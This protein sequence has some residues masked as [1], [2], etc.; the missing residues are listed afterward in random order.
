[1]Y[2]NKIHQDEEN[3]GCLKK[4]GDITALRKSQL[5]LTH[6]ILHD[7]DSPLNDTNH[8]LC[9][10]EFCALIFYVKRHQQ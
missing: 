8:H 3:F 6:T 2:L 4:D 1:M 10:Y 9:Q 5:I 7:D